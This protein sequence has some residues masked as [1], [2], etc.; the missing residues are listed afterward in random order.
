MALASWALLS[1]QDGKEYLGVSGD[2]SNGVIEGMVEAST[3]ACEDYTGRLLASRTYTNEIYDGDGSYGLTLRQYPV[4]ACT[5][6][7]FLSSSP[8][9]VWTSYTTSTYGLYIVE[10]VKETIALRDL[11]F[12]RGPQ[13]V[14]IPSYTAGLT[15]IPSKLKQACRVVLLGMWKSRDK[16]LSGIAS[17][18]FPG[19][20]TVTYRAPELVPLE[21]RQMLDPY[22]RWSA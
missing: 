14:R 13:S 8:P 18:S 7:E 22:K 16:Q 5:A 19:G 21:A 1:L 15:S 12:P 6:V 20:Q 17:Q 9:D 4:T 11:V 10:P 3:L 2:E